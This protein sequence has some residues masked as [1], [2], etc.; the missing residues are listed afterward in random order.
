ME[1]VEKR[2]GVFLENSE[3]ILELLEENGIVHR[4]MMLELEQLVQNTPQLNSQKKRN[5]EMAIVEEMVVRVA[6]GIKMNNELSKEA[7][8][9]DMEMNLL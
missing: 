7:D 5:S 6:E 9:C 1:Q 2:K 8:K 4:K 3:G